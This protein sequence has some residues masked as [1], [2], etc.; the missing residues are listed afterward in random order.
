MASDMELWDPFRYMRRLR[1]RMFDIFPFQEMDSGIREPLVDV[2]DK[3][4]SLQITA[5]LPGVDKKGIE[6]NVEENSVAIKAESKHEARE[7]RE[8]EGYYFHERAYERFFRKVP[9]PAE[10]IPNKATAEF[11]NGILTIDLPKK[12]PEER[13]KGFKLQ[14]K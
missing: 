5:E 13:G 10:V 2:I 11:N 7:E 9:L 14:I 12:H 6:I 8:K 1:Q 4:N 3:G